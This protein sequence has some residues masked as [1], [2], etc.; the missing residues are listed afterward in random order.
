ME[1]WSE[2]DWVM[3]YLVYGGVDSN[4]RGDFELDRLV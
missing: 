4:A 3:V 1:E 2:Y